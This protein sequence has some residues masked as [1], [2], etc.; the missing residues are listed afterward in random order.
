MFQESTGAKSLVKQLIV[1]KRWCHNS[2]GWAGWPRWT[3]RCYTHPDPQRP[4][5]TSTT[6]VSCGAG[7][8][9]EES[10]ASGGC[11]SARWAAADQNLP[12]SPAGKHGPLPLFLRLILFCY[13]LLLLF[14]WFQSLVKVMTLS[15]RQD[16]VR[17]FILIFTDC[18]ANV[19]PISN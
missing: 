8:V 12:D 15:E 7:A 17:C 6:F 1:E 2:G 3:M 13:S 18:T 10:G 11:Q 9:W 4:T 19:C 14:V 5:Q 16:L